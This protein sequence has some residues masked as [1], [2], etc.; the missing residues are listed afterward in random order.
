MCQSPGSTPGGPD[1]RQPACIRHA[2]LT[3]VI[4][5]IH[6]QSRGTY[7]APRV[8]AELRLG[9]GIT[10]GHNAVAMLMK[11]AGLAGQLATTPDLGFNRGFQNR[12]THLQGACHTFLTQYENLA[13]YLPT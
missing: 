2:W 6:E 1:R 11:R 8:H 5:H 13:A 7:G 3:D 10:V 12:V 9:H 4:C